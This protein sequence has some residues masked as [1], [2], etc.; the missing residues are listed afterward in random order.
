MKTK[1]IVQSLRNV[2]ALMSWGNLHI[3]NRLR[4]IR[5][6]K[7]KSYYAGESLQDARKALIATRTPELSAPESK[8]V[9]LWLESES[10]SEV[11][12]FWQGR[13]FLDHRGWF[14]DSFQDETI[15]TCAVR[16]VRFPK[17]VFYAVKSEGGIRV[18]LDEWEEIDYSDTCSDYQAGD[19]VEYSA[20][21][22]IQGNDSTTRREAKESVEENE[23]WHAEQ[24]KAEA[25]S[26]LAS[27]R[28]D[29]RN[30]IADLR[31]A[32]PALGEYPAIVNSVRVSLRKMLAQAETL[33]TEI[34][35]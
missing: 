16:L 21:S 19:T 11:S 33:R 25:K 8:E 10:D 2:P 1:H 32:C 3:K 12:D 15:E 22:I 31:K 29:V 7:G 5:E 9:Y 24:R 27:V 26:E 30:L 35:A 20:K 23:R 6:R 14:T 34:R 13:K 28:A 4:M 17:L 18:H